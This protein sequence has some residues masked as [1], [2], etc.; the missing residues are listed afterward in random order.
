MGHI[1]NTRYLTYFED[2]RLAFVAS[3]PK[4]DEGQAYI[5][6]RI[7]VDYLFPVRFRQGLTLDVQQWVG[8]IGTTSYTLHGELF[9]GA[10]PVARSEVV[11]VAYTYPDDGK[12]PLTDEERE[13]LSRYVEQ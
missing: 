11:L 5:A 12:R 1:N 13:F 8:R 3:G 2:A 7:A 9:D 10:Q 4:R 6:A